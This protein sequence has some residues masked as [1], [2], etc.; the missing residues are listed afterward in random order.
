MNTFESRSISSQSA[1]E[2]ASRM[3]IFGIADPSLSFYINVLKQRLRSR[4]WAHLSVLDSLL[5]FY[6]DLAVNIIQFVFRGS[7]LFHQITTKNADRV[8]LLPFSHLIRFAVALRISH[9][10]AAIPVGDHL[11]EKRTL[12]ATYALKRRLGCLAHSHDVHAIHPI[13]RN[14]IAFGFLANL[15]YRRGTLDRCAHAILIVLAHPQDGQLPYFGE[16][17]GLMKIT[18]I[19]CP[20]AKHAQG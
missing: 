5:D 8:M 14:A 3:V 7:L 16:I 13:V 11:Q 19:S 4:L 17:E 6:S 12:A 15:G 20:V 1:L 9:G 2:M 10:V 18:N